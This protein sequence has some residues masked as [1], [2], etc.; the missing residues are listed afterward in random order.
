MTQREILQS[1]DLDHY[2]S[3]RKYTYRHTATHVGWSAQEMN[4]A[5]ARRC[6]RLA[7]SQVWTLQISTERSPRLLQWYFEQSEP[8]K[9]DHWIPQADHLERMAT[10][11]PF[12]FRL[13]D[14]KASRFHNKQRLRVERPAWR[15]GVFDDLGGSPHMIIN[16]LKKLDMRWFIYLLHL[17]ILRMSSY[18]SLRMEIIPF[19]NSMLVTPFAGNAVAWYL[20]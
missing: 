12:P 11:R 4:A 16:I 1:Y 2:Y 3:E 15:Q 18:H 13:S 5:L 17:A 7:L 6:H 8:V 10:R 19:S 9:C 14:Q 20:T